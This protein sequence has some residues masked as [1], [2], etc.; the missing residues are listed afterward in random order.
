[1]I[2]KIIFT[3]ADL[4]LSEWDKEYKTIS[5]LTECAARLFG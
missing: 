1:M 5:W 2:E 4:C 3:G